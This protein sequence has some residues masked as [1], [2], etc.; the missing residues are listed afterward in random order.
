M[1]RCAP[2]D[3]AVPHPLLNAGVLASVG[4]LNFPIPEAIDFLIEQLQVH[5]MTKLGEHGDVSPEVSR[6]VLIAALLT[7]NEKGL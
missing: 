6:R 4:I 3:R 1:S 5:G 7:P 2:R